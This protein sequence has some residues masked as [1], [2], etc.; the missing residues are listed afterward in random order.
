MHRILL[1]PI[2][3]LCL[4]ACVEADITLEALGEDT[5]R[6]SGMMQM[7]HLSQDTAW[8]CMPDDGDRQT[9]TDTHLRCEYEKTGSF[10]DITQFL[11]AR[12]AT[13][14]VQEL[15]TR[16]DGR[17]GLRIALN[18]L[19]DGYDEDEDDSDILRFLF[20]DLAIQ[21]TITGNTIESSTRPISQ[22]GRSTALSITPQEAFLPPGQMIEDFEVIIHP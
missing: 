7:A 19:N 20:A 4:S 17:V 9:L 2:A 21:V 5:A 12:G 11:S 6:I 8:F 15:A 10:A 13:R 16:S 22:D 1:A 3:A 18:I 14:Y